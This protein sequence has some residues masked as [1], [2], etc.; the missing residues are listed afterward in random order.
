MHLFQVKIIDIDNDI[1]TIH[2]QDL[3]TQ[4][5][6]VL[7]YNTW[8]QFAIQ[9]PSYDT[10][11]WNCITMTRYYL[12]LTSL[13]KKQ[14]VA[15]LQNSE[16]K[17]LD[18]I[19]KT[20]L[21]VAMPNKWTKAEIIVQKA[22]ELGVDTIIFRPSERSIIKEANTNKLARCEKIAQEATEQSW[23][24]ACPNIVFSS[25]SDFFTS[26]DARF[27]AE[28][29]GKDPSLALSDIAASIKNICIVVWPE[30]W[31]TQQDKD[32][33]WLYESISFGT[34]ILRTETAAILSSRFITQYASAN[35]KST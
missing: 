33:I 31:I 27:L 2:D 23:W 13:T 7:R 30:G 1:L 26:F 29:T 4:M 6:S 10:I 22:T 28:N 19:S 12:A 14:I 21:A 25:S 11:T 32:T 3:A 18:H 9:V 8:K 35:K 24:R 20:S 15:Q 34:N 16:T 5:R 17:E